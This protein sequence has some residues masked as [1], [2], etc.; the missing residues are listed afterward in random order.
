MRAFVLSVVLN[1]LMI[2]LGTLGGFVKSL[3][4]LAIV[5]RMIAAPPSYLVAWLIHP[6][7]QSVGMIAAAMVEG[8]TASIVFYTLIA[9]VVLRLAPRRSSWKN[10]DNRA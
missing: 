10:N 9:W 5:S 2:M 1:S 3:S 8:L 7:A 4:F 6:K